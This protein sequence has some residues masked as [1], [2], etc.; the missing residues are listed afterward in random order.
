MEPQENR[1]L[2]LIKA[3][4]AHQAAEASLSDL[5]Q[6]SSDALYTAMLGR[7]RQNLSELSADNQNS[8]PEDTV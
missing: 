6:D 4:N 7:I 5:M 3:I 8:D 2:A 1:Q